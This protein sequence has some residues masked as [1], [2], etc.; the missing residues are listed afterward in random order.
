[1]C[2]FVVVLFCDSFSCDDIMQEFAR[3]CE[4]LLAEFLAHGKAFLHHFTQPHHVNL[5]VRRTLSPRSLDH[6]SASPL[7]MFAISGIS[8]G[9]HLL[10]LGK[11][12]VS[13]LDQFAKD[14]TIAQ[15]T[16]AHALHNRSPTLDH[17]GRVVL[18]EFGAFLGNIMIIQGIPKLSLASGHDVPETLAEAFTNLNTGACCPRTG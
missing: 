5:L 18:H 14:C 11:C 12:G 15:S 2:C 8:A 16:T 10:Q 7:F 1:M 3:L 13:H 6:H 4:P 9:V 17:I